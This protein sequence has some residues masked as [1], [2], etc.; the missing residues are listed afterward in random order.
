M[1]ESPYCRGSF[2][3][4]AAPRYERDSLDDFVLSEYLNRFVDRQSLYC[5]S[6][7][8]CRRGSKHGV[9]D[10]LFGGF[11][12]SEKQWRHR[13]VGNHLDLPGQRFFASVD[14]Y[15]RCG[16]EC[17]RIVAAAVRRRTP[18][19]SEAEERAFRELS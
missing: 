18:G 16:R 3:R 9:V 2:A 14:A 15:Q 11:D 17:D 4:S 19:T 13:A 5:V 6:I 1:N 10:C 8:G 12:R 7:P